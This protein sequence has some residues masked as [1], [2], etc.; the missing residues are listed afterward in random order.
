[1][2]LDARLPLTSGFADSWQQSDC[3]LQLLQLAVRVTLVN[4]SLF[5]TGQRHAQFLRHTGIGKN[6]RERVPQRVK[7]KREHLAARFSP[8]LSRITRC[9]MCAR[10]RIFRNALMSGLMLRCASD[11]NRT[12]HRSLALART[13]SNLQAP[14][15][16]RDDSR[17]SCLDRSRIVLM[18][19]TRSMCL[20]LQG[21]RNLT[22]AL[23]RYRTR[24]R[25]KPLPFRLQPPQR[26]R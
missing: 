7:G 17:R 15:E 12:L 14:D 1:M 9:S 10:S 2:A 18:A 23:R 24:M 3:I 26:A 11:G 5:V 6:R 20:P 16:S 21:S 8:L 19:E 22:R 13:T 25:I 4:R